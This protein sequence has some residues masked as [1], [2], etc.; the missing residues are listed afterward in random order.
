MWENL[1]Q[2]N[3]HK[4]LKIKVFIQLNENSPITKAL[5]VKDFVWY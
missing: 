1:Q 3:F 5:G 2:Q 4:L